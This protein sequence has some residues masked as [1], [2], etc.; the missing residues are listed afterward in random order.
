MNIG[1]FLSRMQ[2]LHIGHLGII[3]KVLAEN[4]KLL[5]LIGSANKKGTVRNPIRDRT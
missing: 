5:I 3:D 4:D 1:V 2:P